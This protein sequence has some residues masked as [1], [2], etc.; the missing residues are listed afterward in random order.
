[1]LSDPGLIASFYVSTGMTTE[2]R[3]SSLF[4]HVV[5]MMEK[6]QV[7]NVMFMVSSVPSRV[8]PSIAMIMKYSG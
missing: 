2:I 8:R 7:S 6:L 5:G 1:M 4:E 3:Y